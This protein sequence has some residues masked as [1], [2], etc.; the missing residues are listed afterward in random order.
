MKPKPK[1]QRRIMTPL[2]LDPEQ[3]AA[4]TELSKTTRVP[5]AVYM[6]EALADLLAKYAKTLKR[7]GAK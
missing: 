7:G 2:Y 6:R 3:K 4:L 5:A 1:R